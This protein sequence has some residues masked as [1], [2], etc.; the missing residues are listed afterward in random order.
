MNNFWVTFEVYEVDITKLQGYQ[1]IIGN[2]VL[3]WGA[4]K[5]S[6]ARQDIVQMA[7]RQVNQRLLLTVQ[8][9]QGIQYASFGIHLPSTV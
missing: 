2:L 4:E 9:C 7:V 8:W 1:E 5:N 6:D 3:M